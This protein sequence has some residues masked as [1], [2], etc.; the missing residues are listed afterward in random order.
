MIR[1]Q[2]CN[3]QPGRRKEQKSS[4]STEENANRSEETQHGS[5]QSPSHIGNEQENGKKLNKRIRWSREEMKEEVLYFT[6]IKEMT[7]REH[8]EEV[9]KLWRERNTVARINLDAKALLNQ[10]NYISKAQR[11][12]AVEIDE[13]R[14]NIRLELGEATEDY[15]NEVNGD[16]TDANGMEYQKRDKENENTDCGKA[17]INKHPSAEGQQQTLKN[18]L[19]EDLQIMCIK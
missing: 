6:Y 14:E 16:R 15:K 10:K 9:Y 5:F 2:N 8:Y 4:D 17:Q 13:V 18:K 11:L 3:T 7:L 19:K 12:T 1:K